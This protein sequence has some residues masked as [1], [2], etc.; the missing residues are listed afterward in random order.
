MKIIQMLRETIF[1]KGKIRIFNK[2]EHVNELR[3]RVDHYRLL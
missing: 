3:K 2:K 1:Q